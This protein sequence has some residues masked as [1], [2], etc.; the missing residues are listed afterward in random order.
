MKTFFFLLVT[1]MTHA[2]AYTLN[3]NFSGA[4]KNHKVHVYIDELSSCAMAGITV[5][6][7]VDMINPAAD[8]FWNRVP[9]SNL[10]LHNGGISPNTA[11]ITTG[12]LCAPTDQ[13]CITAAGPNVI[14]P[15]SGIV[16][17]CNND[18]NN[19]KDPAV[20]AVTVPNNFSGSK[21]TGAVILINDSSNTFSN[22]T[23]DGKIAVIA[24]EIG[25]A[26]G[27]GHTDDKAALMYFKAIDER[28]ALGKDDMLGVSYLYPMKM[29]GGGLLGGCGTIK[30]NDSS[31]PTHPPLWQTGGALFLMI[32]LFELI[33]LLN[34]TNARPAA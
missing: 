16:I 9:T 3:N 25:H 29:D 8:K 32:A 15:V 1:L 18:A 28:R 27:L 33:R 14:A 6:D 21:I 17:S 4:F 10:S 2:E 5:Y 23:R 19:F 12:I 22:L 13:A 31:P 34:R 20:L 30:N 26:I 7:L 24:H 11:N